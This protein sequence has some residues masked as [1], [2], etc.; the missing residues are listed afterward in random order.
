MLKSSNLPY[1][2]TF[3]SPVEMTGLADDEYYTVYIY[4]NDKTSG[5]GTQILK[6]KMYTAAIELYEDYYP[7]ESDAN[8]TQIRVLMDYK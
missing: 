7:L 5:D 6:Q 4:W 8:T 1:T 2:Y 3:S